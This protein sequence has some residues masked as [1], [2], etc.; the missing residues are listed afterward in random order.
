MSD[1][2]IMVLGVPRSGTSMTAKLVKEW[3]AQAGE[4]QHFDQPD[5]FNQ[6]GYWEYVPLKQFLRELLRACDASIIDPPTAAQ[7]QALALDPHWRTRG[8]SLLAA[9]GDNI[10]FWK[11]PMLAILLPFW[12]ELGGNPAYIVCIRSPISGA[13]SQKRMFESRILQRDTPVDGFPLDGALVLWQHSMLS[14]LN[15]TDSSSKKIFVSY[16]Q[17]ITNYAAACARLHSDLNTIFGVTGDLAAMLRVVDPTLQ[18]HSDDPDSFFNAASATR[19]QKDLYRFLLSKIDN[20]DAPF[21][22]EHFP[23]PPNWQ[24]ILHDLQA[25]HAQFQPP[26]R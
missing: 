9:M 3:G 25:W 26:P 10:W 5:A 11:H 22:P 6:Q 8:L 7:L 13:L 18:H 16:E 12:R 19:A 24:E 17:T 4:D 1:R 15:N 21:I 14:I 20:P 2:S 23:L